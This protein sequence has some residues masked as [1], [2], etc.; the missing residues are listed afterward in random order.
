MAKKDT[1]IRLELKSEKNKQAE[2]ITESELLKVQLSV[3]IKRIEDLGVGIYVIYNMHEPLDIYRD[4]FRVR[5]FCRLAKEQSGRVFKVFKTLPEAVAF[6]ENMQDAVK[7]LKKTG[8]FDSE[9]QPTQDNKP[10]QET[11][12]NRVRDL[13]M[14]ERKK[15][16][17]RLGAR[18]ALEIFWAMGISLDDLKTLTGNMEQELKLAFFDAGMDIADFTA[19]MTLKEKM[20]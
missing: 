1:G 5:L 15:Q 8:Y 17:M 20:K 6:L 12:V 11:L 7:V 10:E 9:S 19:L 13:L 16:G 14:K 4:R 3:L 18:S 2:R